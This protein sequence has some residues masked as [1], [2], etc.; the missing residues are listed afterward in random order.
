MNID[1]GSSEEEAKR[2]Q[3]QFQFSI[4]IIGIDSYMIEI[5]R[6]S[7]AICFLKIIYLPLLCD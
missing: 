7:V 4:N 3:F 6:K 5:E 2:I 1:L